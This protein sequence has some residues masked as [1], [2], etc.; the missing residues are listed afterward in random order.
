M[1]L[2]GVQPRKPLR[3]SE[4]RAHFYLF[5]MGILVEHQELRRNT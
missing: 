3:L 2:R 4:F 5:R 1:V